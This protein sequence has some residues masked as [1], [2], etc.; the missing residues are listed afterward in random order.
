MKIILTLA[1]FAA[2]GLFYFQNADKE[3][4]NSLRKPAELS[5]E[6]QINTIL[7]ETKNISNFSNA[8]TI[9][10]EIK[11]ELKNLQS[12]KARVFAE[13]IN[14][15]IHSKGILSKLAPVIAEYPILSL[16]I[17][18]SLKDASQNTP[19]GIQHV[20]ILIERLL[21]PAKTYNTAQEV[22]KAFIENRFLLPR[23][24][25]LHSS[26]IS[27]SKKYPVDDGVRDIMNL[28]IEDLM[29]S[30]TIL[31]PNQYKNITL[32]SAHLYMLISYTEKLISYGHYLSSYN[33]DRFGE[34]TSKSLK[35]TAKKADIL[36]IGYKQKLASSN[37]VSRIPYHTRLKK[38]YYA[39]TLTL[40][41]WAIEKNL[42]QKSKKW[43]IQSLESEVNAIVLGKQS[44]PHS[45]EIQ[46]SADFLSNMSNKS[47]AAVMQELEYFQTNEEQEFITPK[48]GKIFRINPSQIF[49]QQ[50]PHIRDLKNL[51]PL[52]HDTRTTKKT[53]GM[54][55]INLD[56]GK[57]LTWQ[58]P[59]F[60]KILPDASN[61]N[62][63]SQLGALGTHPATRTLATWL[64]LFY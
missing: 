13:I 47:Q 33:L 43:L 59:S 2:V 58:D 36:I 24:T 1:S 30:K 41:P 60:A 19:K 16:G 22:Q 55:M 14:V 35:S 40:H 50:N 31:I 48:S 5:I 53:N 12:E 20:H 44:E 10:L 4:L 64:G 38:T 63:R 51:F 9:L 8:D 26:L 3:N 29:S 62:I 37:K 25:K 42:L 49:N 54:K 23:L 34:L 28:N 7:K 32:N 15:L 52:S 11:N 17:V 39:K 6:K 45:S 21:L 46:L 61:N 56:Y 27:L 18:K 57:A